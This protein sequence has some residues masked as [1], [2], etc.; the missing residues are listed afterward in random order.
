MGP[1]IGGARARCRPLLPCGHREIPDPHRARRRLSHYREPGCADRR[2]AAGLGP[3]LCDPPRLVMF[4]ERKRYDVI[5]CLD[6]RL[7]VIWPALAYAKAHGIP[8][9]SDWIDWWG[10]GGLIEE[11]RP[12][13]YK[14]TLGGVE[15]WFE[16]HYRAKLDGLT[17]ISHALMRR[18]IDLGC[19]PERCI[20]I[21]GA[22]DMTTFANPSTKE[23][24]RA[25]AGLPLDAP[26]VCFSGLDV[27]IDLPLAVRAFEIIHE[28]MPDARLLLV[29][30]T[31]AEARAASSPATPLPAITALGKVPYK[32][33]P[34]V[35][36]AAY[37]FL[38]PYP[39]K[40]V[41]VGRWPNKIGDYMAV[42]RPTVANPVGELNELFQRFPVGL[43][44]G[45]TA[46]DMAASSL[47]L[48]RDPELANEIGR[49]ARKA[50]ETDL[51]WSSQIERL[52]NWYQDILTAKSQSSSYRGVPQPHVP[53]SPAG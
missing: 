29:G 14:A 38:L 11:R 12:G 13:W 2:G 20:V 35:L 42:G 41:N 36:P 31:E 4:R 48:L 26:I 27:L 21:N 6:T 28:K 23:E 43:L 25:R 5:H 52:E 45:E 7:A 32:E 17:T 33:L 44:A 50:A 8:I 53:A 51:S 22:A 46:E 18:G 24:A 34:S 9:V 1:R 10:R 16:E 47:H 3:L 40:I 37:L 49:K 15:T 30:P 39:N 19:K